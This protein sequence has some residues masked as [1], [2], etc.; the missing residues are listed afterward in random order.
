[1]AS[2]LHK[3]VKVV[4]DDETSKTKTVFEHDDG[5]VAYLRAIVAAFKREM[6]GPTAEHSGGFVEGNTKNRRGNPAE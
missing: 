1:M 3:G 5:L 6:Q 4:F 2:Y